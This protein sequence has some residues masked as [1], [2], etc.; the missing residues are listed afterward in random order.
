MLS[1]PR[2]RALEVLRHQS[3]EAVYDA[4]GNERRR[5]VLGGLAE[6]RVDE[7][8][9]QDLVAIRRPDERDILSRFLQDHWMFKVKILENSPS[10]YKRREKVTFTDDEDHGEYR[11]Y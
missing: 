6:T 9:Q 11:T 7:Q 5:H 8:K 2:K 10:Y 4:V 1:G 3:Y